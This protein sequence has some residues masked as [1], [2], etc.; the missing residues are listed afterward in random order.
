MAIRT[1]P[2]SALIPRSSCLNIAL[3]AGEYSGDIQGAALAEALRE[4]CSGVRDSAQSEPH[5][6]HPTPR[7]L[8]LWG[9]GGVRMREAG[10]KLR[11]DSTHWAVMGT[12]EALK[13]A[14]RLLWVLSRVKR[15]LLAARPDVLVLIDF[16]AFNARA[17]AWAKRQGLRVF[18]Y[19]PPGSWRRGPLRPGP[20]SL[21][22]VTDRST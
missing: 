5:T 9:I 2:S 20:R 11:F 12:Y 7:P 13:L 18:Y 8:T 19:F 22:A 16:G 14:P 1:G 21:P 6:Q 10:V 17:A 3:F 15:D 4:R